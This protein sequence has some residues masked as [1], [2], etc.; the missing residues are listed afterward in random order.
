MPISGSARASVVR[1]RPTI[2]AASPGL[3]SRCKDLALVR[4]GAELV[5]ALQEVL[6]AGENV[7]EL[8]DGGESLA[9]CH[10]RGSP[11][12]TDFRQKLAEI[13]AW[14]HRRDR[15]QGRA[16]ADAWVTTQQAV[17]DTELGSSGTVRLLA[18]VGMSPELT[19]RQLLLA[20]FPLEWI[21][22]DSPT[23]AE[24]AFEMPS[25]RPCGARNCDAVLATLHAP[26]NAESDAIR[27]GR[28]C[29]PIADPWPSARP[30]DSRARPRVQPPLP[31]LPFQPRPLAGGARPNSPTRP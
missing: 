29:D 16:V 28:S 30:T 15:E 11:C 20:G 8:V 31:P 17:S 3:K 25:R 24:S 22:R 9:H 21:R 1:S 13:R 4:L 19:V 12:S 2:S 26:R 10:S 6:A 7:P 18:E 14:G 27:A 23:V 5:H